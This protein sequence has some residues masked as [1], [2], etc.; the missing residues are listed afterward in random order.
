MNTRLHGISFAELPYIRKNEILTV[1]REAGKP[2]DSEARPSYSV[3]L[4]GY[5]VG[6]IPLVETLKEEALKARD[7]FRKKW[8]K[9]FETLTKEELRRVAVE[10]N[11]SGKLIKMHEFE[12]V[13]KEVMRRIARARMLECENVEIIRDCLYTEMNKDHTTPT[14]QALP[15]YYD[16]VEGLNYKEIGDICSISVRFDFA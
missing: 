7:G 16:K 15:A 6:Y 11:K 3:R 5:H 2:W 9:E 12:F 1:I 14:G 4:E 13:G 10:L 8:K